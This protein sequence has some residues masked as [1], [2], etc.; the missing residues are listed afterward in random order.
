MTSASLENRVRRLIRELIT[1]AHELVAGARSTSLSI[2]PAL[3]AKLRLADI[4]L[5]GLRKAAYDE[6]SNTERENGASK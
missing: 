1:E 4:A 6:G 2:S 3:K 5:N